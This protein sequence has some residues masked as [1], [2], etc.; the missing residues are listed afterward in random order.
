MRNL[1]IKFIYYL[2]YRIIY[3]KN[4]GIENAGGGVHSGKIE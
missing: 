3:S 1:S 2:K 4:A